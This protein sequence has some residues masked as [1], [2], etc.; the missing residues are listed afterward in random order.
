M[1]MRKWSQIV[2]AVQHG[3]SLVELMVVIAII[4]ILAAIAVPMYQN[5]TVRADW[6]DA[7]SGVSGYTNA[8]SQCL[9]QNNGVYN[10]KCDDK[11]LVGAVLPGKVGNGNVTPSQNK[12]AAAV[13]W[14]TRAGAITAAS[15]S[16]APIV[17]TGTGTNNSNCAL[18]FV[19]N[20]AETQGYFKWTIGHIELVKSNNDC[21]SQTSYP[22][23]SA[24]AS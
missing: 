9:L 18:V 15:K 16:T 6:A 13:S 17:L 5:Q 14:G 24:S 8:L 19:H 4:G 20:N 1:F 12:L 7:I 21:T 2:K 3:F 11:A 23:T 10:G 22:V